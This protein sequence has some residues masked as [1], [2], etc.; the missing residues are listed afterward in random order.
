MEK[1]LIELQSNFTKVYNDILD[2]IPLTTFQ[3]VNKGCINMVRYA[4][5]EN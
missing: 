5:P 2:R 1:I 4:S 3:K